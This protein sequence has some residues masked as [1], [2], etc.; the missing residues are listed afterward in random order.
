MARRKRSY[1]AKSNKGKA[2]EVFLN[3]FLTSSS[4]N[5]KETV[6]EKSFATKAAKERER[7]AK[8][9]AKEKEREEKERER[10]ANEERREND[11]RIK[12]EEPYKK[13]LKLELEKLGL[14]PL[15]WIISLITNQAI[16][17]GVTPAKMY[18]YFIEGNEA[19][20]SEEIADVWI[21]EER[22]ECFGYAH[23]VILIKLKG[24]IDQ[25]FLE[26]KDKSILREMGEDI[27][28]AYS[29]HETLKKVVTDC[30]PQSDAINHPLFKNLLQ[31]Y[32]NFEY[33]VEDLFDY[34]LSVAKMFSYD[35]IPF[36][37]LCIDNKWTLDEATCSEEYVSLTSKKMRYCEDLAN[38]SKW[39][40]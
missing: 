33:I 7:V 8:A 35:V 36:L 30:R 38:Q 28:D 31:R 12:K 4:A 17:Q 16:E 24:W 2:G 29:E 6:K 19:Y 40:Q 37:R 32:K 27:W 26:E 15:S 23:R 18:S 3:N 20:L 13:R 34:D 22:R 11:R 10:V 5:Q 25:D 39:D 1:F 21:K 9:E 14:H